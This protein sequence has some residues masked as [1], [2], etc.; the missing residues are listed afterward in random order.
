M[1]MPVCSL[2]RHVALAFVSYVYIHT[3]EVIGMRVCQDL[4]TSISET[5]TP[6]TRGS[7]PLNHF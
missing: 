2:G 7:P 5:P 6:E 4:G 1:C 3:Q